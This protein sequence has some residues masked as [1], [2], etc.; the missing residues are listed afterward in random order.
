M[1]LFEYLGAVY[2]WI[3]LCLVNPI[4]GKKSPS[5]KEVLSP[6]EDSDE[7]VDI[8]AAGLSNKVVGFIITMII[9]AILARF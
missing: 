2:K 8:M 5:F 4:L 9:C 3:F 1:Y 7:V 6:L